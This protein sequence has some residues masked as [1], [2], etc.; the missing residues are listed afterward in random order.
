MQLKIVSLGSAEPVAALMG[1]SA[2]S[3]KLRV[4]EKSKGQ[5]DKGITSPTGNVY[6]TLK[7]GSRLF[8]H[9]FD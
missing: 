6:I 5:N 3:K 2:R 9:V 7:K 4:Q 1:L 8:N